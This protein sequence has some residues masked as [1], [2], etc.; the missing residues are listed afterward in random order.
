MCS[1]QSRI[2]NVMQKLS[3]E[4]LAKNKIV[5]TVESCTGGG[6]SGAL[7]AVS[8]SS[9]YI[10]QAFVTYSNE[11]KIRLVGVS[12]ESLE[13]YGAVSEIVVKQM[14]EGG[15]KNANSDFAI[16][17]SGVAGPTGGSEDKPVGTV[18]IGLAT[19]TEL[20]TERCF[21]LG[22]RA[23]VREQTVLRSLELL[24]EQIAT[25]KNQ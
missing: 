8:G 18:W 4:L 20:I 12:R 2:D 10:E 11:A 21:F 17:V 9:A 19:P 24:Y 16:A 6:I 1:H 3:I 13:S 15:R 7:T 22:D 25:A 23:A 5:T 14:A